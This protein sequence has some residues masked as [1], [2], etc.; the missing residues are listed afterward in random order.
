MP[1]FKKGKNIKQAML[2]YTELYYTEER[3]RTLNA[4]FRTMK[5]RVILQDIFKCK[6]T[7]MKNF[8]VIR[9]LHLN[10]D[11]NVARIELKEPEMERRNHYRM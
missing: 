10:I 2:Y 3:K 5:E 7:V 6:I 8:V 1:F 4:D 9:K 11:G